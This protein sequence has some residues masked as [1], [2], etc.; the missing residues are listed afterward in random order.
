MSHTLKTNTSIEEIQSITKNM[1]KLEMEKW[2]HR[3][4]NELLFI[5]IQFLKQIEEEKKMKEENQKLKEANDTFT[6]GAK[7]TIESNCK[8]YQENYK[9]K[10]ENEST[11]SLCDHF[12]I[13]NK[14]HY[15]ELQELKE[16]NEELTK[17]SNAKSDIIRNMFDCIIKYANIDDG[18]YIH[19]EWGH[20]YIDEWNDIVS[21]EINEAIKDINKDES[22]IEW[23]TDGYQFDLNIKDEEEEEQ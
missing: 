10:K 21:I 13:L 9:L 11:K 20:K 22:G 7:R 5:N 15:D 2:I 4:A 12:E 6:L 16:E 23:V 17:K 3:Q 18:F 19:R 14:K 1:D 8:L